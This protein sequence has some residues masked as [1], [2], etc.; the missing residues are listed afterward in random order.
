MP[1]QYPSISQIQFAAHLELLCGLHQALKGYDLLISDVMSSGS[2][3]GLTQAEKKITSG[4]EETYSS[5]HIS[6]ETT[7]EWWW[8]AEQELEVEELTKAVTEKLEGVHR[9]LTTS[10]QERTNKLLL[11]LGVITV[12]LTIITIIV[13]IIK[14]LREN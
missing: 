6:S 8:M 4:L 14:N 13:A 11:E 9:I 10:A 3:S 1:S 12:I 7:K 2:T 5:R